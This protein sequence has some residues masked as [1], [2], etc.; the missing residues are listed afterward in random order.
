MLS[1]VRYLQSLKTGLD[2][3]A[4]GQSGRPGL[5][6]VSFE[7]SSLSVAHKSFLLG[8]LNGY[9]VSEVLSNGR[10]AVSQLERRR[11]TC[12]S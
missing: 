2:A 11:G 5:R 3:D 7:P 8:G 1:H 6:E 9:H 4:V 12:L 10:A